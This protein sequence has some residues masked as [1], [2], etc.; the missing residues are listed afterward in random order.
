MKLMVTGIPMD[1]E[2]GV[3]A[4]D[5]SGK[6]S[7]E[8]K[9]EALAARINGR[10]ISLVTPIEEDGVL[11]IVG[12]NDEDGRRTLRHTASHVLAQAVKHL[13]PEAKLAIGPA[14]ENGFYYDFDVDEPFTPEFLAQVEKEM[15]KLIKRNERV[16]RFELPRARRSS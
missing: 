9:K 4:L 16:E 11:E 13:R 12:F 7:P 8:L 10:V 6:I 5:L 3:N 1:V 15:Q 14:I 2:A